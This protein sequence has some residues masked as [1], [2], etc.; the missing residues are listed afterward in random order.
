LLEFTP[1]ADARLDRIDE[2]LIDSYVQHRRKAVSPGSVNREL[3]TLRKALRLAQE[4]RIIDRVP[5]IRMLPGER[6]R[7][8]VLNRAQETAY[9]MAA[10][11]PLRDVS[12]MILDTGLRVGEVLALEWQDVRLEPVNGAG[13]GY[14]RVRQGKSKSARRAVRLTVR[15]QSML[16]ARHAARSCP[17]VFTAEDGKGPLSAFTLEDQHS[18][19]RKEL[20]LPKELVLHSLR[21][22]MLTRLGESGRDAFT[23]M[24]IAGHSTVMI[25][26]RYVHP[27][28]EAMDRAFRRLEAFNAEAGENGLEGEKR[29]QPATIPA[30]VNEPSESTI[31]QAL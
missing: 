23:L 2:S 19:L 11:Q 28:G 21:H 3:A 4:W 24:R 14:L 26:Q 25:S 6:V 31:V 9:L 29:Q 13:A 12:M 30:T 18:R 5:R 10:P 20:G 8:L 16:E 17:W 7:E 15:V 22:T 27:S 1:L